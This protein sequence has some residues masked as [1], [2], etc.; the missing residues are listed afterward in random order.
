MSNSSGSASNASAHSDDGLP[1][2]ITSDVASTTGGALTEEL[3]QST[4]VVED[5]PPSC[6]TS[7]T[8]NVEI[9][10]EQPFNGFKR[11]R[12]ANREV[13]ESSKEEVPEEPQPKRKPGRPR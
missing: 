11:K 12:K 3:A 2:P 1:A 7:H 5:S 6:L 4:P 13:A 9:S 10:P 8:D